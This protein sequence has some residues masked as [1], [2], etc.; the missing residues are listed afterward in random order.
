MHV[1][2]VARIDV[3][4]MREAAALVQ[5][6]MSVTIVDFEKDRARPREEDIQGI[7][8]KHARVPPGWY[9]PARFKPWFLVK[10]AQAFMLGALAVLRTPADVYHA[11][12]E[13]ALPACYIAAR[14]RRKPL[15][16]DAHELPLVQAPLTRWRRLCALSCRVLSGMMKRCAGVITV[17]PPLVQEL[18]QRYGGPTAVLVRN[19]PVYQTPAAS[20]RLRRQLGLGP[21]TQIAL[22][23]GAISLDRDLDR[24][25]QAAKFLNPN[26][27]IVMIGRGPVREQLEALIAAEGVG[28]R[29]KLFPWVPYEELLA[30]TASADLGLA[31]FSGASSLS[32]KLCL[33]N[34]FFE[35]LMAGLPVLASPLEAVVDLIQTYDVGCVA[36]SLE[37]VEIARAINA[38]LADSAALARMRRNALAAAQQD[39]RW[40]V[41]QQ[42]LLR[43]YQNVLFN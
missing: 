5:A 24:L 9:T 2:G 14:V 22:Y 42:H 41:E 8:L 16:F 34:K 25:V 15:I 31:L 10:L 29:V 28:D 26:I 21:Q 19:V 37:P 3:R 36:A 7:H 30:L 38:L 27:V 12:D 4:V 11:H 6:G 17:S 43:L 23:Q 39:L 13:R 18:Q 20:D 1:L 35:Y 32:V 40:D 33:P